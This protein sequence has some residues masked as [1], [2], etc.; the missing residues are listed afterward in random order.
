M[1]VCIGRLL[2]KKSKKSTP[3]RQMAVLPEVQEALESLA[4]LLEMPDWVNH[5]ASETLTVGF[6]QVP[7]CTTMV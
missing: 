4:K 3:C 2:F 1:A 6:P 7:L 5:L